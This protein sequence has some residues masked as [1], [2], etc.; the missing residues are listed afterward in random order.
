MHTTPSSP[1]LTLAEAIAEHMR[2]ASAEANTKRFVEK[3]RREE[4]ER[5][6]T[7]PAP[8][9]P[10]TDRFFSDGGEV[11]YDAWQHARMRL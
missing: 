1:T 6:E 10:A 11:D 5:V 8:M 7:S 2:P 3:R 4:P 9:D